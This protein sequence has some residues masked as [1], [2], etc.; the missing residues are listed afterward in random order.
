M[1]QRCGFNERQGLNEANQ[2][3]AKQRSSLFFGSLANANP[4]S[5]PS[6]KPQS[7]PNSAKRSTQRERP[8]GRLTR[9]SLVWSTRQREPSPYGPVISVSS[10]QALCP[11]FGDSGNEGQA[12]GSHSFVDASPCP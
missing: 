7:T 9:Y 1:L 12:Q 8:D 11:R 5:S 6:N 10:L 3:C 4:A 2:E